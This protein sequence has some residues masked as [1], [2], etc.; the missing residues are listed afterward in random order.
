M[1]DYIK[2]ADAY[3]IAVHGTDPDVSGRYL[4]YNGYITNCFDYSAIHKRWN[5]MDWMTQKQAKMLEIGSVKYW[6][7]IPE[8]ER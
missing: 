8:V 5:C 1:T 6:M 3:R 2:K 7:P 4:T